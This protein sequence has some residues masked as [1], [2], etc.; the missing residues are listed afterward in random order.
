MSGHEIAR[1]RAGASPTGLI[2]VQIQ[3]HHLNPLQ[4]NS[5]Y[6]GV[7][8]GLSSAALCPVGLDDLLLGFAKDAV[9]FTHF[10]EGI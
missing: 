4:Y 5:L 2:S 1:A 8:C 7:K 9:L 10:S 3:P 6:S